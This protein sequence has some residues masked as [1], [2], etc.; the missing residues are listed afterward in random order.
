MKQIVHFPV[1]TPTQVALRFVDGKPVEGRWGPQVMFALEDDRVM[2]VPPFVR[3]RIEELAIAAGEPFEIIKQEVRTGTRKRIEWRVRRIPQQPASSPNNAAAAAE[4]LT[5]GEGH[6]NGSTNGR[7]GHPPDGDD[8][9]GKTFLPA[10]L[11]EAITGT[12]CRAMELALT[13][14]T[15]IAQRV[16]GHAA[17]RSYSLRFS[18][19]DIRAIG[20]TL[21]I[22]TMREAGVRWQ[23]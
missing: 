19:E 11:S 13:G 22:Q 15:E 2:Y 23:A 5:S 9:A 16:E 10:P 17:S 3:Q 12:G 4:A 21:F 6:S 18:S 8:P 20:L 1:N 14:A 7:N